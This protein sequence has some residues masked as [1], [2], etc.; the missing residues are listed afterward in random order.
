MFLQ[1]DNFMMLR[2]S[3]LTGPM[4]NDIDDL[5]PFWSN[6]LGSLFSCPW[7]R[8]II[9]SNSPS[10]FA[11]FQ[12]KLYRTA[13]NNYVRSRCISKSPA[14]RRRIDFNSLGISKSL[15]L[16]TT[17]TFSTMRIKRKTELVWCVRAKII[18]FFD[19]SIYVYIV[20][21]YFNIPPTPTI[22]LLLP[23]Y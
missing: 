22:P 6:I 16:K 23:I 2:V 11:Q 1:W 17:F 12:Q 14:S 7:D 8:C 5:W 9:C 15:F 20:F 10:E 3:I 4:K 19:I 18:F 21:F 13:E